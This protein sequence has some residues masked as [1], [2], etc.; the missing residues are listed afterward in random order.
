VLDY[1]AMNRRPAHPER[2]DK[3]LG[4]TLKSLKMERRIQQE[5]AVLNWGQVVGERI[6]AQAIPLRIRDSI[7]FVRVE[8]ASWRNELVFLKSK[9]IQE[10]NQSVKANVIK[11]IVFT[12]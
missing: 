10:L 3:I 7:L 2:I 1:E 11:D 12:N 8:N 5:T 4:R 9:I 6:A